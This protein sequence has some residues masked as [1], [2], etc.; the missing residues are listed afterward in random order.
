VQEVTFH[1][2]GTREPG[3]ELDELTERDLARRFAALNMSDIR[4]K[5]EEGRYVNVGLRGDE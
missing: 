2:D 1:P 5:T 4:R 3:L